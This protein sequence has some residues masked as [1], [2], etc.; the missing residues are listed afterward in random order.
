MPMTA[1]SLLLAAAALAAHASIGAG[2]A[3]A[4]QWPGEFHG[5]ETIARDR[6][7]WFALRIDRGRARLEPVE[8]RVEAVHDPILDA[9]EERSG[10][11]VGVPTLDEAPLALVRGNG[12]TAGPLLAAAL[13]S[14][15]LAPNGVRIVEARALP[16]L[17]LALECG[18]ASVSDDAGGFVCELRL[19]D[20]LVEQVLHTFA[21]S[22]D[23]DGTILIGDDG[24]VELRFA[25]DLDRDGRI[26]LVLDLR[27][28]YNV[29]RTEVW[30]SGD[31]ASGDLVRRASAHDL[32]GC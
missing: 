24:G 3:F 15:T 17:E 13:E 23:P 25:G 10:R 27:D 28:H 1:S 9:D 26:D 29:Q 2:D 22:K 19:R 6:E 20:D 16:A 11:R 32:T 21:A 4:W 14:T 5:D 18:A 12:T 8:V 31:A 30:L 7:P